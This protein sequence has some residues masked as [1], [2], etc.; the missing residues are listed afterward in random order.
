MPL[1]TWFFLILLSGVVN[2]QVLYY[3]DFEKAKEFSESVQ[4][5]YQNNAYHIFAK[6]GRVSYNPKRIFDNFS[7]TIKTEFID[8]SE[9]SAYGLIFR[10]ADY[11]N[12]YSFGIYGNGNFFIGGE[13]KNKWFDL[14]PDQPS[15]EINRKGINYLGVA[16]FGPE[17]TFYINGKEVYRLKDK[18][19]T[20]GRVGVIAFKGAHIHFDDLFVYKSPSEAGNTGS[21]AEEPYILEGDYEPDADALFIDNFSD[22]IGGFSESDNAHYE[23]GY[24]VIWNTADAHYSWQNFYQT[25]Y[26]IEVNYRVRQWEPKG[27][28]GLTVRQNGITDFY[29]YGITAEGLAFFDKRKK[30][31]AH[32][33]WQDTIQDFRK[34]ELFRLKVIC[35][36][37]EFTLY[38]DSLQ[39]GVVRD[40]QQILEFFN[41]GFYASKN[42]ELQVHSVKVSPNAKD[43]TA[44]VS[45]IFESP[46]FWVSI[47]I[48]LPAVAII[49]MKILRALNAKNN[50]RRQIY[51]DLKNRI[52]QQHGTI[53]NRMIMQT[54][55]VSE[56]ESKEILTRL[57]TELNGIPMYSADG[58]VLYDFPD[59][60]RK[61]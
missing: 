50:R 15:A 52:G 11:D 53:S 30:D 20:K 56:S 36:H 58:E 35:S 45:A 10:A 46:C 59:Y 42:V 24:Y 2:G 44:M 1:K 41:F 18:A 31:V 54:Y 14:I 25:D 13:M 22:R 47:F 39:L 51:N 5:N 37:D 3:E 49:L 34:D 7:L 60:M 28:V 8:G 17:M 38:I 48:I 32:R 19:Y 33:L 55:H 26:T 21:F 61:G 12:F 4:A 9:S 27:Y 43:L 40:P 16:C 23:R 57:G 29:G 6:D